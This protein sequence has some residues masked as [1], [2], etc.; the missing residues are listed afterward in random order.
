LSIVA[1]RCAGYDGDHAHNLLAAAFRVGGHW[2]SFA[3]L[4]NDCADGAI[5]RERL[6]SGA[7]RSLCFPAAAVATFSFF[8]DWRF[9]AAVRCPVGPDVHPIPGTVCV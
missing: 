2:H 5:R 1:R 4:E 9:A 8:A 6:L 7:L 3:H